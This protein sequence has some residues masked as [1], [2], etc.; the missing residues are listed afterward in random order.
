MQEIRFEIAKYE[1][2]RHNGDNASHIIAVY[3]KRGNNPKI[4]V[5]EELCATA[6]AVQNLLLGATS[7]N[8]AALWNTGGLIFHPVMKT[9]FGLAEADQLIGFLY[10]GY[11]DSPPKAGERIVPLEEKIDWRE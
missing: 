11:S 2:I 9:Y 5:I 1:K 7:L 10:F 4:T 8:I 3:M 6:A